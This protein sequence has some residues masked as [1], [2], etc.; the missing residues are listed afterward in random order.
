M[1]EIPSA[2]Y[3][4]RNR[5]N[6]SDMNDI[7]TE[8]KTDLNAARLFLEEWGTMGRLRFPNIKGELF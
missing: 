1:G 3:P 5:F 6:V 4:G 2:K 8:A 7:K